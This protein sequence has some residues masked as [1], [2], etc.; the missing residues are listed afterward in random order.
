MNTQPKFRSLQFFASPEGDEFGT[1]ITELGGYRLE[2]MDDADTPYW[3]VLFVTD[4]FDD[5][6]KVADAPTPNAAMSKARDHWSARCTGCL[7]AE[8]D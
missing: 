4:V 6:E 2:L 8:V 1:V 5:G 7:L 3:N